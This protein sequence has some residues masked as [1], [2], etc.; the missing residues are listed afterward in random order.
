MAL[1][2][3][4]VRN[5][6]ARAANAGWLNLVHTSTPHRTGGAFQFFKLVYEGGDG[7]GIFTGGEGEKAPKLAAT[8]IP[9]LAIR[10]NS[11]RFLDSKEGINS[12]F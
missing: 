3:G 4:S 6:N 2:F 1:Q 7:G 10:I 12:P 9:H 11:A 8:Q 5:Q